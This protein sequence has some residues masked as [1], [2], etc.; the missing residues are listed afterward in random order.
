MNKLTSALLTAAVLI[1]GVLPLAAQQNRVSPH[2]TISTNF[3]GTRITLT[4][5]RPYTKHPRTGEVRQIW[6]GLVPYDQVWRT[7]ANEATLFI[8]QKDLVM[9]GKNIPAGAYTVFTLPKADGSAQLILNKQLGQWGT[10]HD[11]SKDLARIDLEKKELSS[12]VNQFTMAIEKKSSDQ[13]VLKLIWEDREYSAP[14][15]IKK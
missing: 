3:D 6:G 13:G 14:F 11:A 12:P 8:T 15:T 7:G 5:G 2:E 10:E 1:G 4:Y 9:A